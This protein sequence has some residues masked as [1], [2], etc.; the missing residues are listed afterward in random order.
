MAQRRVRARVI[1]EKEIE[2]RD[3]SRTM[4]NGF[5]LELSGGKE[6]GPLVWVVCTEDPEVSFNF[7]IG[8]FSLPIGLGMVS[9]GKADIVFED[10]SKFLGEG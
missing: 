4:G 7:L 1:S 3:F 9:G 10:S 6:L 5:V 2:G 8:S